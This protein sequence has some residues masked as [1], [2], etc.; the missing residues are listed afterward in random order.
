[1]AQ[2]LK[3]VHGTEIWSCD[4]SGKSFQSRDALS[5]HVLKAHLMKKETPKEKSSANLNCAH[6]SRTLLAANSFQYRRHLCEVFTL[7]S[8]QHGQGRRGDTCFCVFQNFQNRVSLQGTY[9]TS[10]KIHVTTTKVYEFFVWVFMRP[11][12]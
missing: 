12:Y 6:C 10:S 9:C 7:L 3:N 1:M 11:L 4:E 2:H 5:K 8:Q